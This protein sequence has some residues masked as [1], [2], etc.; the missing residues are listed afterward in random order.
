MGRRRRSRKIVRRVK[1]AI[2]K[3]FSCPR[4]GQKAVSVTVKKSEGK[5][6]VKCGHCQLTYEFDVA[7]LLQPVDYYNRF[8]DKYFEGG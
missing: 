7:P 5:V 2:P 8:I 3:V 6:V 4:C 1:K